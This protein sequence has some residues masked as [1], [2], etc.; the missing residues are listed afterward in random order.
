MRHE[1]GPVAKYDGDPQLRAARAWMPIFGPISAI[2]MTTM[3]MKMSRRA[4]GVT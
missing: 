1:A 2:T 4:A 3:T